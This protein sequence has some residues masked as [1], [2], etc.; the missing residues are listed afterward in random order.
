[1]ADSLAGT[2][3]IVPEADLQTAADAVQRQVAA[4][5]VQDILSDVGR[6]VMEE[7]R[8]VAFV[9]QRGV[10]Q[11]AAPVAPLVTIQASEPAAPVPAAGDAVQVGEAP[12]A[13]SAPGAEAPPLPP[14]KKYH[15]RKG[16]TERYP[17]IALAE[18]PNDVFDAEDEWDHRIQPLVYT[19]SPRARETFRRSL[20]KDERFERLTERDGYWFRRRTPLKRNPDEFL[21]NRSAERERLASDGG[22]EH[23]M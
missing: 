5:S 8:R 19:E 7:L 6:L 15:V 12:E 22:Q 23:L 3:Y 16:G 10:A 13:V 9:A 18:I 4:M 17:D 11:P 20:E 2:L 21:A 14:G 1:M